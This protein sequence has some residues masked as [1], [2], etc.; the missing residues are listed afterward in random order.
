MIAI[1]RDNHQHAAAL[2]QEV[3]LANR[4]EQLELSR[5]ISF[6]NARLL[7]HRGDNAEAFILLS[8]LEDYY[9]DDIERKAYYQLVRW[10]HD[11]QQLSVTAVGQI[12]A[13]LTSRFD[14]RSLI[15]V[16]ILSYAYLEHAR[17]AVDNASL[18]QGQRI[19][20]Q[21]VKHF[22]LLELTSKISKSFKFAADFYGRHG[23]SVKSDYYLAAHRKLTPDN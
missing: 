18:D 7:L 16:E 20:E 23:D 8:N 10:S 19:I 22:S 15:N 9:Q 1:S 14:A 4:I 21:A 3:E 13:T 11:Y 5:A 12:I 17:W 6:T 2:I